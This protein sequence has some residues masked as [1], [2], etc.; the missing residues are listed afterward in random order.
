MD[1]ILTSDAGVSIKSFFE[2][3]Q[4]DKPYRC[5]RYGFYLCYNV[6]LCILLDLLLVG[7][8]TVPV[9][10]FKVLVLFER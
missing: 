4:K 8:R 9:E 10:L 1:L 7:L 5:V 6:F 2:L 3:F